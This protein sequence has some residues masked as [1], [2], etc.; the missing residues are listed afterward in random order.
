MEKFNNLKDKGLKCVEKYGNV[1]H[2]E[3]DSIYKEFRKTQ[4]QIEQ[5]GYRDMTAEEY[6]QW[7]DDVEEEKERRRKEELNQ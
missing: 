5:L 4:E 6:R 3:T 2:K 1:F 7:M